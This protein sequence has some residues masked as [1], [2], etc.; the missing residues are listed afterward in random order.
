MSLSELVESYSNKEW[1]ERTLEHCRW[2]DGFVS[3]D[4]GAREHSCFVAGGRQYWQC[5]QCPT[6]T[7][8][9]SGTVFHASKLPP[10]KWFQVIYR[11]TKNR[12]NVSAWSI[13]RDLG[14]RSSSARRVE[15]KSREAMR[16][17]E[18]RRLLQGVVTADD[19]VSALSMPG[20]Q[21][22]APRTRH[23]SWPPSN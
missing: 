17:R 14:V 16:Q 19:P 12:V 5:S 21:V 20:I 6:Q 8:A 13:K 10:T 2:P 4:C 22:A 11:V 18:S 1:C 15:H 23:R 9:C 7:T 3:P